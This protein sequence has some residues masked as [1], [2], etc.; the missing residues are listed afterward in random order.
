[1]LSSK[2]E[3][4]QPVFQSLPMDYVAPVFRP[5]SESQSLLLQITLGCSHN[6]C[7]YC[8]MYKGKAYRVRSIAEIKKDIFRTSLYFQKHGGW[9]RRIFLCD[10]DALGAPFDLLLEV[11]NFLELQFPNVERIGICRGPLLLKS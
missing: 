7:T 3:V 4:E 11:L 6:K 8:A 5:P 1:M 9:P 2:S 10:G